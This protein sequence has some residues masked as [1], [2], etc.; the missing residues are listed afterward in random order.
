MSSNSPIEM[1]ITEFLAYLKERKVVLNVKD[2]KLLIDAPKGVL[3]DDLVLALRSRKPELINYLLLFPS[4]SSPAPAIN[5]DQPFELSLGQESMWYL[6]RLDKT[7]FAFNVGFAATI[8]AKIDEPAMAVAITQLINAHPILR[9]H[10]VVAEQNHTNEHAADVVQITTPSEAIKDPLKVVSAV[11]WSEQQQ[12]QALLAEYVM[13][14]NLSTGPIIRAVLWTGR[15]ADETSLVIVAPHIAVD[16][17]SLWQLIDEIRQIYQQKTTGKVASIAPEIGLYSEYISQQKHFLSTQ[18][19]S[20][21]ID[22]WKEKL[23]NIPPYLSLPCDAERPLRQTFN[24]DSY[25]VCITSQLSDQLMGFAKQQNVSLYSVLMAAYQT[26]LFRVSGQN[27]FVVGAPLS[28]RISKK[29]EHSVGFFVNPMPIVAQLDASMTFQYLV[30]QTSQN[31]LEA[32]DYQELPFSQL[33]DALDCQRDPQYSPVFQ[34]AFVLQSLAQVSDFAEHMLRIDKDYN[35]PD[36]FIYQPVKT[37]IPFGSLTITPIAL[38]QQEGVLDLMLEAVTGPKGLILAFKYNT[39]LFDVTTIQSWS[40]QLVLLLEQSVLFPN[41]KL[42]DFNFLNSMAYQAEMES[43]SGAVES[44]SSTDL[45]DGFVRHAKTFPDDIA[46]IYGDDQLSY[47]QFECRS[48]HLAAY[49]HT[50]GVGHGDVVGVFAE[51][52]FE[53]MLGIYASLMAGAV[54]LPLDP[55]LPD[56]RIDGL[57]DDG[58]VTCILAQAKHVTRLSPAK[59]SV[60][61]E[62][63]A[64]DRG[65]KNTE[66]S[67]GIELRPNSTAYILYTSG[68]TGKPKGVMISHLAISNR[69]QWMQSCYQLKRH[70]RVLHKTPISFDVSIWELFWPLREGATLVLAEPGGHKDG[71]YLEHLLRKKAITTVHFVPAMLRSFLETAEIQEGAYSLT[72]ILC[73]GESLERQLAVRANTLLNAPVHNLYGP[74]EAAVDVT[75]HELDITDQAD[76]NILTVPIGTPID[77]TQTFV[78]NEALQFVPRG[79]EGELYLGGFNLAHGYLGQARLTATSFIPNPFSKQMGERLYRTGDRVRRLASGALEYLGRND[80]QVKIRGQRIELGEIEA[81][82]A[83]HPSL[84]AAAA[85][86]W[87]AESGARLAVYY[88]HKQYSECLID[89]QALHAWLAERVSSAMLPSSWNRLDKLPLNSSGKLDRKS[90]REPEFWSVSDTAKTKVKPQGITEEMLGDLWCEVLNVKEVF[91]GDDFFQLGGHSLLAAKLVSRVRRFLF[92]EISLAQVFDHPVLSDLAVVLQTQV[93]DPNSI[94][95]SI[96]I[97]AAQ[98]DVICP[99]SSSQQR[100]WVLNKM[101]PESTAYNMPGAIRLKGEL[102]LEALEHAIKDLMLRQRILLSQVTEVAGS[103]ELRFLSLDELNSELLIERVDCSNV[104][105]SQRYDELQK[106]LIALSQHLFDLSTA[107]LFKVRILTFAAKDCAL[108]ICLHHLIADGTSIG[109]LFQEWSALYQLAIEDMNTT[110]EPLDNLKLDYRDFAIW[111]QQQVSTARNKSEL[112]FWQQQLNGLHDLHLLTERQEPVLPITA[113]YEEYR[114]DI[115][116]NLIGQM[117]QL[118][119]EQKTTLFTLMLGVY[120]LLLSRHSQQQNFALAIPT[121]GRFN[122]DL[123]PLIGCFVNTVLFSPYSSNK[124]LNGVT[125]KDFIADVK[126]CL[127]AALEHQNLPFDVLVSN[128]QAT[129]IN[130]MNPLAQALFTFQ[131][132]LQA[133]PLFGVPQA[134]F[135]NHYAS[136]KTFE[137]SLNIEPKNQSFGWSACFEF[138]PSKFSHERLITFSKDYLLLLQ[139]LVSSNECAIA[140]YELT[141][142]VKD[143]C[144]PVNRYAQLQLPASSLQPSLQTD[145]LICAD[146]RLNRTQLEHYVAVLCAELKRQSI[147]AGDVVGSC[148]SPLLST[149]IMLAVDRCD[150]CWAPLK[151]I[152]DHEQISP[153]LLITSQRFLGDPNLGLADQLLSSKSAVWIFQSEGLDADLHIVHKQDVLHFENDNVSDACFYDFAHQC[154]YTKCERHLLVKALSGNDFGLSIHS[155]LPMQNVMD[156]AIKYR[157]LTEGSCLVLSDNTNITLD[158]QR[159]G[160][161]S[162]CLSASQFANLQLEQPEQLA[163]LI[164]IYVIGDL[165][166]GL[167]ASKVAFNHKLNIHN[168]VCSPNGGRPLSSRIWRADKSILIDGNDVGQPIFEDTWWLKGECSDLVSIGVEAQLMVEHE[169]SST[170]KATGLLVSYWGE[171]CYQYLGTT[172]QPNWYDG[173]YL[174]LTILQEYLY[175]QIDVQQVYLPSPSKEALPWTCY[176]TSRTLVQQDE[177]KLLGAMQACF[178]SHML[179]NRIAI[180]GNMPVTQDGRIDISR[181]PIFEQHSPF[182]TDPDRQKS[183]AEVALTAIWRTV[184]QH[185]S[186]SIDDNFFSVGGHSL[187]G[188][189]LVALINRAFGLSMPLQEIFKHPTIATLLT[190]LDQAT[191]EETNCPHDAKPIVSELNKNVALMPLLAVKRQ[192]QFIL[193]PAQYDIWVQ[194]QKLT[195]DNASAYHIPALFMVEGELDHI[196]LHTSVR[197]LLEKYDILR[198]A[199][200]DTIDGP[201]QLIQ[202]RV[203]FDIIVDNGIGWSAEKQKHVIQKAVDQPFNLNS[204]PLVRVHRYELGSQ[205][206]LLLFVFHHLAFDGHSLRYFLDEL[207][208][209]YHS[210]SMVPATLQYQDYV[211]WI[212]KKMQAPESQLSRDFWHQ[213][214]S[215]IEPLQYASERP[216]LNDVSN[217][218]EWFSVDFDAALFSSLE[219]MAKEQ[220]VSVFMLYL[221]A[222][223]AT[224]YRL[225][226][227]HKIVLGAVVSTRTDPA[228]RDMMGLF[229]NNIALPVTLDESKSFPQNLQ[230]IASILMG[231]LS[232]ANYPLGRLVSELQPQTPAGHMPFF[233][234]LVDWQDDVLSDS[235]WSLEGT[236]VHPHRLLSSQCKYDLTLYFRRIRCS[237]NQSSIRLDVEYRSQLYD[238]SEISDFCQRYI[239]LLGDIVQSAV[240]PLARLAVLSK[241]EQQR[242][243]IVSQGPQKQ[244]TSCWLLDRFIV[245]AKRYPDRLALVSET[246]S[247]SY[248]QLWQRSQ[249]LASHLQSQGI[250]HGDV[251]A[252]FSERSLEMMVGIYAVLQAGATYLPLDPDLPDQRLH[253]LI[254]DADVCITLVQRQHAK[255]MAVENRK[256]ILD[257]WQAER[258]PCVIPVFQAIEMLP[259]SSAYLLYTSGSTGKPKGVLVSHAAIV[260]RLEWMQTRYQLDCSDRVL[261]KTPISFDVSI[262]ELF[263]P[264]RAGAVLVLA[265]PGGHR[266]SV[267]LERLIRE[268]AITTLHFVP[269][270]LHSF[271]STAPLQSSNV[272]LLKRIICSGENLESSLAKTANDAF[273]VPVDNLYGPT[274]AAIDVTWYEFDERN[275]AL[276]NTRF[277]VPIGVPIDNT[278]TYVL[279]EAL[280][281]MPQGVVGELYLGGANLAHGYVGQSALTAASFIPS[282]FNMTQAG[283][284]LYRTGD[285]VRRL[286]SGALEYVGRMDGQVKIRGQR[287]ELGEIEAVLTEYPAIDSVAAK[288]WPSDL[289]SKL[290]VYYRINQGVDI[291]VETLERWMSQRVSAAMLPSAWCEMETLPLSDSGK[292]NRKALIEPAVWNTSQVARSKRTAEG[293]TEQLLSQIWA[294]VL[295]RNDIYRDDNFF[296]LGGHSLVAAKMIARVRAQFSVEIALSQVFSTPVLFDFADIIRREKIW[297]TDLAEDLNFD[298]SSAPQRATSKLLKRAF[299]ADSAPVFYPLTPTQKRFWTLH[300]VSTAGNA[301]H[302]FGAVRLRGILDEQALLIAL[303]VLTDRHDSL[304]TRFTEAVGDVVDEPIFAEVIP[305]Y[306]AELDI[307]SLDNA[308]APF[309]DAWLKL[310]INDEFDL[311]LAPPVR[312]KL[313]K[314]ST[315]ESILLVCLHHIL[316]D[317]WSASILMQEWAHLYAQISRH[318]NAE[319]NNVLP[320]DPTT[321]FSKSPHAYADFADWYQGNLNVFIEQQLP[322]W[323]ERLTAVDALQ[324]PVLSPDNVNTGQQSSNVHEAIQHRF[325]IDKSL[326]AKI[327]T[328]ASQCQATPQMVM[329]SALFIL[330]YK[331]SSSTEKNL[332]AAKKMVIGS[333]VAGRDKLEFEDT[334]GAFVNTLAMVANVHHKMDFREVI[335]QVKAFCLLAYQHQDIA[336]ESILDHFPSVR[337]GRHP[338]FQVM[339]VWQSMPAVDWRFAGLQSEEIDLSATQTAFDQTWLF[340]PTM[341][342][343]DGILTVRTDMVGINYIEALSAQLVQMLGNLL[344]APKACIANVSLLSYAEYQKILSFNASLVSLNPITPLESE[345]VSVIDTV[346]AMALETPNEWAIV[347]DELCLTYA[348]LLHKVDLFSEGLIT[349]AQGSHSS[350]NELVIGV[351]CD[352]SIDGVAIILA[353]LAS[354]FVF[355]PLDPAYPATRLEYILK[356]AQPSII[357]ADDALLDSIP[358]DDIPCIA[359][360]RL[361]QPSGSAG[362]ISKQSGGGSSRI[363]DLEQLAYIIYT[364]GST[365]RPKGTLLTHRGLNNLVKSQREPFGLTPN[366]RL[367]QF[368][369]WNF[370]AAIAEIFACLANGST[371]VLPNKEARLPGDELVAQLNT[372]QVTTIA[373][374]PTVLNTLNPIDLPWLKIVVSVGEACSKATVQRWLSQNRQFV[375]AYG[376]TECTVCSTIHTVDTR[377]DLEPITPIGRSI[378][379]VQVY[380]LDANKQVLP[381]GMVGELYIGGIGL[382]RGYLGHVRLTAERFV[383]DHLSSQAGARL[384]R[385]G[386]LARYLL[387][388]ELEFIGRDDEQVKIRGFRVELN[389]I[390]SVLQQ[391]PSLRDATVELREE[392]NIKQLVGYVVAEQNE[393]KIDSQVLIEWLIKWLPDYMVPHR[394]ITLEAMPL[395]PNGK[396]DSQRLPTLV[397]A[398][399][400]TDKTEIRV[401]STANERLL[402]EIWGRFFSLNSV[403]IDQNFFALGGDSIVA[404]QVIASLKQ[405]GFVLNSQQIFNYPTIAELAPLIKHLNNQTFAP[406]IDQHSLPLSPMQRWYLDSLQGSSALDESINAPSPYFTQSVLLKTP[407]NASSAQ[408]LTALRTVIEGSAQFGLRFKQTMSDGGQNHWQQ[409]LVEQRSLYWLEVADMQT[410]VADIADVLR[411][412]IDIKKGPLFAAAW[413]NGSQGASRLLLVAHHL[414]IDAVSWRLFIQRL[415]NNMI[416]SNTATEDDLFI[417]WLSDLTGRAAAISENEARYWADIESTFSQGFIMVDPFAS[418]TVLDER[419]ETVYV[420]EDVT[421]A[422]LS[423]AN[424]SYNTRPEELL[425]ASWWLTCQR[426]VDN[427]NLC[428]K[429]EIEKHGRSN[430]VGDALGWF[431]SLYPLLLSVSESPFIDPVAHAIYVSKEASRAVPKQGMGY[432]L[433]KYMRPDALS[434]EQKTL[435]EHQDSRALSMVFN[436]LGQAGE[437]TDSDHD[438]AFLDEYLG[439]ERDLNAERF[440]DLELT[441]VV[442]RG[443]LRLSLTF[444]AAQIQPSIIATLLSEWQKALTDVVNHTGQTVYT[445]TPSDF[446][447]VDLSTKRLADILTRY[448]NVQTIYP[449]N[450]LQEG[451]LVAIQ[452]DNTNRQSFE[453]I[454]CEFV[455][456]FDARVFGRALTAL[457]E[458][459]PI[460]RS[461][462]DCHGVSAMQ[463]VHKNVEVDVTQMDWRNKKGDSQHALN[464]FVVQQRAIGFSL[465]QELLHRFFLIRLDDQRTYFLWCQDHRQLDGWSLPILLKQLFVFYNQA[466]TG[467]PIQQLNSKKAEQSY[468]GYLTWL[469]QRDLAST[470]AFWR[471]QLTALDLDT[472]LPLIGNKS[473]DALWDQ[474]SFDSNKVTLQLG[475]EESHLIRTFCRQRG[476]TIAT[477]VQGAWALLLDRF[478][479]TTNTRGEKLFGVTL[480]GRDNGVDNIDSVVGMLINTL[481]LR[482]ATHTQHTI[483]EWL[484]DIQ[485]RVNAI[486]SYSYS[487]LADI[488][489]I[490]QSLNNQTSNRNSGLLKSAV[491]VENYPVDSSLNR[492]LTGFSI[493]KVNAYEETHF[494]LTLLVHPSE[495]LALQLMF[496]GHIYSKKQAQT[497]LEGYKHILLSLSRE[498]NASIPLQ[499][500]V[501]CLSEE[502]QSIELR[503]SSGSETVVESLSLLDRFVAHTQRYP[504]HVAL[505][506]G[507]QQLSYAQLDDRSKKLAAHLQIKGVLAGDVVAVCAARSLDMMLAIYAVLQAGAVYLPLDVDLPDKRLNELVIDSHAVMILAQAPQVSRLISGVEC[508]LIEAWQTSN[509][510]QPTAPL[511]PVALMDQ[512]VAYILYTSGS[513]GKPKGVMVSHGAIVNR[514]EWMQSYY[515]LTHGERVLHKT[516]ISFDVSIW[517]LFW[518]L[519]EGAT[520]V[521]ADPGSH[522]DGVYLERLIREMA[523]TTVHFVPAM[524]RG[525]LEYVPLQDRQYV[526]SRIICSGESLERSLA[527][528]ASRALG[529]PV[530]NLYGPTEAAVDVTWHK[531]ISPIQALDDEDDT[532]LSVPI[533]VPISN[534]QIYVLNASLELV[535]SGAIGELYIGGMNLAQGYLGQSALTAT[536][537]IPSPFSTTSGARMYRTGDRV[538]RLPCGALEYLGRNDSQVKIRGQ[539]IELGEVEGVASRYP[540]LEAVAAK[541]WSVGAD[542][543][544]SL[545]FQSKQG[546]SININEA[547]RWMRERVSDALVPSVWQ[548]LDALPLSTS[549]KVDY[550][551]LIEPDLHHQVSQDR[552]KTP[553]SGEVEK[554]LAGIWLSVLNCKEVYREDNF[555]ELGGHSLSAA[556]LVAKIRDHFNVEIPLAHIFDSNS[557]A[558]LA[559]QLEGVT[560]RAVAVKSPQANDNTTLIPLPLSTAQTRLWI[561]QK[562]QPL[563]SAL[564]VVAAFEINDAVDVERLQAAVRALLKQHRVLSSH[565]VSN[566]LDQTAMQQL[567]PIPVRPIEIVDLSHSDSNAVDA[568]QAKIVDQPFSLSAEPLYRFCLVTIDETSWRFIIVVHHILAD[569]WSVDLLFQNLMENYQSNLD[570][571][572]VVEN[573]PD[574][575]TLI[576]Q[577]QF[578]ENEVEQGAARTY[579]CEK[580]DGYQPLMLSQAPQSANISD[581]VEQLKFDIPVHLVEKMSL[582]CKDNQASLFMGL[583]ASLNVLLARLSRQDDLVIGFPVAGRTHTAMH[584]VVG[585]FVNSL[586]MRTQIAPQASFMHV[587]QQV[588]T[589]TLEALEHQALPFE[590]LVELLN[591]PRNQNR[592][593]IF[594]LMVDLQTVDDSTIDNASLSVKPVELLRENSVYDVSFAMRVHNLEDKQ[595]VAGTL[596]YRTDLFSAAQVTVWIDLWFTMLEQMCEQPNQCLSAPQWLPSDQYSLIQQ[597]AYGDKTQPHTGTLHGGFVEQALKYPDSIAVHHL[598]EQISYEQLNHW[599]DQIAYRIL[600]DLP[601][602]SEVVIGICA[603]AGIDMIAAMLGIMKA[604]G[605]Y[606]PLD[607]AFPSSRIESLLKDAGVDLVLTDAAQGEK[608]FGADVTVQSIAVLRK[609]S[610]NR[611][612]L[613]VVQAAN[614]AYVLYTSGSTG[615]PK[616]VAC[617]HSSVINLLADIDQRTALA[618]GERASMWTAFTFDVS[619]YEIFRPLLSGATLYPVP[620][621]IRVDTDS[622]L[623]WYLDNGIH[624]GYL[625]GFIL[626]ELAQYSEGSVEPMTLTSL[627]VGVE[628]IDQQV[629]SQLQCHI[630]GLNIIN[631]YGPTESTVCASLHQFDSMLSGQGITPIGKP[632]NN[633]SIWLV[634]NNFQ[635]V[636]YGSIGEVVIGGK[637]LARGYF[638]QPAMTAEQFVPLPWSND[639]GAVGYRSGDLARWNAQGQL[640]FIGRGDF[641]IKLRGLRIEPNEIVQALNQHAGIENSLVMAQTDSEQY[642][643]LVAYFTQKQG[644]HSAELER[645]SLQAFLATRLPSYYIPNA[646]VELSEFPLTRSGKIDRNALPIAAVA[647][648][649][650]TTWVEASN[651][652]EGLLMQIWQALLD[653]E[654]LS[655]HDNFFQLGGDSI[656]VFRLVAALRKEG[657]ICQASQIFQHQTI[658]SLAFHIDQQNFNGEA[659]QEEAPEPQIA[660]VSPIQK[661]FFEQHFSEPGQWNQGL[662]LR[663]T[664]A[665][666]S[667][668]IHSALLCLQ[669]QYAAL[670]TYFVEQEDGWQQCVHGLDEPTKAIHLAHFNFAFSSTSSEG[671]AAMLRV[672]EQLNTPFQLSQGPLFRVALVEW[673]DVESNSDIEPHKQLIF[674]AHHLIVDALS[675]LVIGD[676]LESLCAAKHTELPSRPSRMANNLDWAER[677]QKHALLL[678]HKNSSEAKNL[679]SELPLD[680]DVDNIDQENLVGSEVVLHTILALELDVTNEYAILVAALGQ[681]ISSWSEQLDTVI[682]VES[683]GRSSMFPE[684]DLSTSIGWFT[685]LN[686]VTVNSE[687]L[688]LE[689][690]QDV[691]QQLVT[692]LDSGVINSV[693]NAYHAQ[694]P[695]KNALVS[696]NYFGSVDAQ[697]NKEASTRLFQAEAI[698]PSHLQHEKNHRPFL[699]ELS[700]ARKSKNLEITWVYSRNMHH[701]STIKALSDDYI[702]NIKRLSESVLSNVTDQSSTLGLSIDQ[703]DDLLDELSLFDE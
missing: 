430:D 692:L 4:S 185:D 279:N 612:V 582:L 224:F 45:L 329:L 390:A 248:Q 370:D 346:C 183:Q 299:L 274:E 78:L 526:L 400:V 656:L 15:N 103:P 176:V 686:S 35:Q 429:I 614:L 388:G 204:A 489:S 435:Q 171:G 341:N 335:Q 197:L 5:D 127:L 472:S 503:L 501:S 543:Y 647:Q 226:G 265:E 48:R 697:T 403:D 121:D 360:S 663:L 637:G 74:T 467:K 148:V 302:I 592:H 556:K 396:V 229:L 412:R 29:Y 433:L 639:L 90:L 615:K 313:A 471:D 394:Y 439:K 636:P 300:N 76:S 427:A 642:T 565:I 380:V 336:F 424:V 619:V 294:D 680:Y 65:S 522:K 293:L 570:F 108:V 544:L 307:V 387:N 568:L 399:L 257:D 310:Q 130:G 635:L 92:L 337:D 644:A 670:R 232:H 215:V 474:R 202:E 311:V 450:S 247:L 577:N 376:P 469:N 258:T 684:V 514:L 391:H 371:L 330:L 323:Q 295:E 480:S 411:A 264:L 476:I 113:D 233:D 404:I 432:G 425:L 648:E 589:N 283:S 465:E 608:S 324:L 524:L 21:Q 417:R 602:S 379:Q 527:E 496:D 244:V 519:R 203:E 327:Q 484:G 13:P 164:N 194:C 502:Q 622:L 355:L 36:D 175:G 533:G 486:Q 351:Y 26:L 30:A 262:W 700:I 322:F 304:R 218:A 499:S 382:A 693:R 131:E 594:Q 199:I 405:Q 374:P 423:S 342:G 23:A 50:N 284:R 230:N 99:L 105:P 364:S 79:V 630:K 82:L 38:P 365:G 511:Q 668:T 168:V 126:H 443:R 560:A 667:Q 611:V 373:L 605:A 415:S 389:E 654:S 547:K 139:Q 102:N 410:S 579:W 558:Q 200:I 539:R 172:D 115:P 207:S 571:E 418:N 234:V 316:A 256:V 158:L 296:D 250:T 270:M 634:D 306:Q 191:L 454:S 3:D 217:Q 154:F 553:A 63:W 11:G 132:T 169:S 659:S 298:Q 520:L 134:D 485:S 561:M 211:Y 626:S 2:D 46:L 385:T 73:S 319:A 225:T 49:L 277:S 624:S 409:S 223:Y 19:C 515:G 17:W 153:S 328:Q 141:S 460:L 110:K 305:S 312:F 146:T 482:V 528:H 41:T 356:D 18:K 129:R 437:A 252:V 75:W 242:E 588:R 198:T 431:T 267:Y 151:T 34:V 285:R 33:F 93:S 369:S 12:R 83:E 657:V 688:A 449:V 628:P 595:T 434:I 97:S 37:E 9:T 463:V 159:L 662:V 192:Q 658:A 156:Y 498:S 584:Q 537:F 246:D 282:P 529:A 261:H 407:V 500:L 182:L 137:I 675:W 64:Q 216:R 673:H 195:T 510:S 120:W 161:T 512:S 691:D 117:Q 597:L 206:N 567:L 43:S 281:L 338:I 461:S 240:T 107:P 56:Q 86:V 44:I 386:D 596:S 452:R 508:V 227:Q 535:P 196:K 604:G 228:L 288:I 238:A 442:H 607:P 325:H 555:F 632:V 678:S 513:T 591:V 67:N 272:Y 254:I 468:S 413:I 462:F 523:I 188:A 222:L 317:G 625:P 326:F 347:S 165:V 273:N 518:P 10:Y 549:G 84:E 428:L 333:V 683:H 340:T 679:P 660:P 699:L 210:S 368:A 55:D 422:I 209:V 655:T 610:M 672:C 301:H 275:H 6:S 290:A 359:L 530:Y 303:Q 155:V 600:A 255:R 292:V 162:L 444:S 266:D 458:S 466:N 408:I 123:E 57:I 638:G 59:T 652:T 606:L 581:E 1:T 541:V 60:V 27:D 366:K 674:I 189:Q 20:S 80:G 98:K 617:Q 245:L 646:F 569:G 456:D 545:Y 509:R 268:K 618:V 616:G 259:Q 575:L 239:H 181:L 52:S 31:I 219:R 497:L 621:N 536:S 321:V 94:K 289:G 101:E 58:G 47:G 243:L 701:E 125:G 128:L 260:N 149:I 620:E 361:R 633:V 269:A 488:Q 309:V 358:T 54:Y 112:I 133:E 478:G 353:I 14:I 397:S 280:E 150:A 572:Q 627:L 479:D 587:L 62:P 70:E 459:Q 167:Q 504:N 446:E 314:L 201:V 68:S 453:Q 24:G 685:T 448:S 590:Q 287:I 593:P 491:V 580:L 22:Y 357:I 393:T 395:T 87:P 494:P 419:C 554:A 315:D 687:L 416:M 505:I 114:F 174:D 320:L 664:Q 39:D 384:Y 671:K 136:G 85:R 473:V 212:D 576:Q 682:C 599:S 118:A 193:S 372:H 208:A 698:T 490:Y 308:S 157:S 332:S 96:A 25:T 231:A 152:D 578:S 66:G 629:L 214:L 40:E 447:H 122:A 532:G 213:Q 690:I 205:Q 566:E 51:R 457:F 362:L 237:D 95:P 77:N 286:E 562:I 383:P 263:W 470:D 69:L 546:V 669:R 551:A 455:G 665:L 179:P 145:V 601:D 278:Q 406:L 253:D 42:I 119:I 694:E 585:C 492:S 276:S 109:I 344:E 160:A 334:V 464:A 445:P 91:R 7:G 414:V 696:L 241:E 613:P 236:K 71:V 220:N 170:H 481:P 643:Q 421:Q 666:P 681:V 367:L 550:K 392:N 695:I 495:Q 173:H 552:E 563:S 564:N 542:T 111:Q 573:K 378:A 291:A 493:E 517:E 354:G 72:R 475:G 402:T 88:Q 124:T 438:F 135:F 180:L 16:G 538:R 184:L 297:S 641:Q 235:S 440:S 138:Q 531:H 375:N 506:Q 251:V 143:Y 350:E 574:Y 339:M 100:L 631:G 28:G 653:V 651:P 516:P 349:L 190:F 144:R 557:L 398:S 116:A 689:Q 661:W 677:L 32:L 525:F 441:S 53:M 420:C 603:H 147:G 142:I 640:E 534:T 483:S 609:L 249:N 106:H 348:E 521:L 702:S 345:H 598:G 507:Q 187:S 343:L 61:L 89:A 163:S 331:Q 166:N 186:F 703:F 81:I 477:L 140:Q 623:D 318:D 583:T 586:V 221:S 436:Y 401:A 548:A 178:T 271:L 645:E 352:K 381:V 649:K 377:A 8:H 363:I 177:I 487:N 451:M 426:Y 104:A 540:G 676:Q 559:T 650:A